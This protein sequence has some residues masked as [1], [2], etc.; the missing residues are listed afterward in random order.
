MAIEARIR[1]L[2]HR[3]RNLDK[4]IEEQTRHPA[5]DD[6]K[7]RQLKLKKLHLKEELEALRQRLN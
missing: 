6:L 5:F 4:E 3:H 1:E 7:L 2:N